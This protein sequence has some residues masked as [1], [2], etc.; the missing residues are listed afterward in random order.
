MPIISSLGGNPEVL[1]VYSTTNQGSAGNV[2][3]LKTLDSSRG[4]ITGASVDFGL[5]EV[6]LP[7]GDYLV[8]F[9]IGIGGTGFA[10]QRVSSRARNTTSG[11][12]VGGGPAN[13]SIG[14]PN[15]TAV[16]SGDGVISIGTGEKLILEYHSIDGGLGT[17]TN[18]PSGWSAS[19]TITP[20]KT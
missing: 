1:N 9:F 10:A 7:A 4:F 16:L 13:N 15:F 12:V 2:W 11:Q 3:A 20:I 17:P 8:N 14:G 5:N 6:T 19:M 18:S